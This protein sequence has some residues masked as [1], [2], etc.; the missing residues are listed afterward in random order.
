MQDNCNDK[1][2]WTML[3]ICLGVAVISVLACIGAWNIGRFH[4]RSLNATQDNDYIEMY[5]D[6]SDGDIVESNIVLEGVGGQDK[7]D[8]SFDFETQ[9]DVIHATSTTGVKEVVIESTED[10]II[11]TSEANPI[12]YKINADEIHNLTHEELYNIA[13]VLYLNGKTN[14]MSKE[15]RE[16]LLELFVPVR[17]KV[18]DGG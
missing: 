3:V 7:D 2:G 18:E 6:Q 13:L 14:S 9:S 17:F 15:L 12:L 5:H 10:R 8:L 16:E 4:Y 11:F 1:S